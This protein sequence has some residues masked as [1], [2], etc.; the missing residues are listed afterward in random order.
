MI[1]CLVKL[2]CQENLTTQA[3][4]A[5]QDALKDNKNNKAIFMTWE[6][7][8]LTEWIEYVVSSHPCFYASKVWL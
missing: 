3:L 7:D 4:S 5:V 2:G 6:G 8:L 1:D